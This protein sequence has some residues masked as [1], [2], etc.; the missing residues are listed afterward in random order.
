MLAEARRQ[1]APLVLLDIAL[2][3]DVEPRAGELPSVFLYNIDD[4]Q[5]VMSR[6]EEARLAEVVPAEELVADHS[7]RFWRWYLTRE[8][9]PLIRGL[10]AHGENVRRAE[11]ERLFTNMDG[12]S[13]GDRE[14]IKAATRRLLNKLLHPST[15]A[16][17]WAAY[18]PN[19]LSF[20]DGLSSELGI[21]EGL[22]DGGESAEGSSAGEEAEDVESEERD[23][24]MH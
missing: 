11:L 5:K 24:A 20:I 9:A 7:S 13:D 4:L 19:A 14:R 22:S 18:E 15:V 8:V 21:A 1:T 3:R 16:L 17:R 23:E 10:R 6:T 12:L 2:P